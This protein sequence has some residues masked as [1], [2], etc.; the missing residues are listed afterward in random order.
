MKDL[1]TRNYHV[2]VTL[3]DPNSTEIEDYM[4][5]PYFCTDDDDYG[6]GTYLWWT[7]DNGYDIRYDTDYDPDHEIAYLADFMDRRWSGKNGAWKLVSV[8]IARII[9]EGGEQ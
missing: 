5:D 6:N 7:C 3:A 4:Y 2:L 9:Q 1:T 8:S